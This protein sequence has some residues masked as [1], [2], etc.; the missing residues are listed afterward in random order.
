MASVYKRKSDRA[1][2]KAGKWTCCYLG[3]DGKKK[4]SAGVT[5]K[6]ESQRRANQLEAEALAVREGRVDPAES[7]RRRA[8]LRPLA[9]HLADYRIDLLA[10]GDTEKHVKDA[11]NA[12]ARLLGDAA[13]PNVADL[14]PDR[15]RASLG[16]LRASGLSA[17]RCNFYLGSAKS[18]ATWLAESNRIGEAPRGLMK[19]TPYNEKADRRLVRRAIGKAELDRLLDVTERGDPIVAGR[20]PRSEGY[21]RDSRRWIA[22]PERAALYRLAMGTGFR[23]KELRTL[24]PEC[25]RLDRPDPSI[26][27]DPKEE[28]NRN[29]TVQP[30]ARE[31]AAWFRPYLEGKSPG[32]P[33]LQVPIRTAD[34]LRADLAKADILYKDASGRVVDF[35][36]LRHSYI[37]HLI[38]SGVNPKIVQILARHST[39]TLTLDR[40]THVEDDDVRKALEG[41]SVDESAPE[42]AAAILFPGPGRRP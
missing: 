17:R 38:A 4:Q 10:K 18:F 25:F 30:I 24:T 27:L 28:K 12:L 1:R 23:A 15:I 34:M 21:R 22:G 42:G 31:F 41:G 35:H 13:C 14:A 29:G 26:V 11:A 5:D 16:R 19:L 39:I 20:C 36:A 7:G 9:D 3:A 6:A 32:E 2:G 37:T 40:Y 8:A 33:V